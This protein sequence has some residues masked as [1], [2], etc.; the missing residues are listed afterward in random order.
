MYVPSLPFV[1]PLR[2]FP[3]A[4]KDNKSL[5]ESPPKK[6]NSIDT[7]TPPAAH[8]SCVLHAFEISPI[9]IAIISAVAN[10]NNLLQIKQVVLSWI[11]IK[12]GNPHVLAKRSL[13]RST[14]KQFN[15]KNVPI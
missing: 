5:F 2:D 4:Q 14:F 8:P 13:Q 11:G 7:H 10:I 6:T 1:M 3:F 12:H 9:Y 15:F